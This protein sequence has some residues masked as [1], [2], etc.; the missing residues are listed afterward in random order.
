MQ[1]ES[2][3]DCAIKAIGIT[4]PA[5][6]LEME[7]ISNHSNHGVLFS[8]GDMA[9]TDSVI[10]DLFSK[11]TTPVKMHTPNIPTALWYTAALHKLPPTLSR[12]QDHQALL[13]FSGTMTKLSSKLLSI[14]RSRRAKRL[15]QMDTLSIQVNT[16]PP[17][18]LSFLFP[19]TRGWLVARASPFPLSHR[20]WRLQFSQYP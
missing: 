4:L 5:Q 3:T 1:S 8:S 19:S 14:C 7:D 12:P 18:P 20:F 11:S 17:P 15:L 9:T 2:P 13:L 16:P 6:K 10:S